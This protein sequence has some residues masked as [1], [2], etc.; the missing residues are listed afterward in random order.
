MNNITAPD[1]AIR[2]YWVASRG[3]GRRAL[4]SNAANR[5]C[6]NSWNARSGMRGGIA[7]MV[8]VAKPF[9]PTAGI[10]SS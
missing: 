8:A 5:P 1:D 7:I 6:I 9:R 3:I 4:M 10:S 2:V